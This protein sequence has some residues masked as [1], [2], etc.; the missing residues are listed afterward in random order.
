MMRSTTTLSAAVFA[1]MLA[2]SAALASSQTPQT[3]DIDDVPAGTY[4]LDSLH[5]KVTWAVDH[6]GFSTYQ[7]QFSGITG[8]L[9]LADDPADSSLN[10]EIP[11][12]QVITGSAL[13]DHLQGEDFF[14]TSQHATAT[15]TSTRIEMD[16]DDEATIHGDL[17]LN[18]QTHPLT[19]DAHFNRAAIYPFD[20]T[21]RLGFDGEATLTR[22]EWGITY[23]LPEGD[24]GM[25]ISDDVELDI[26]AEFTPQQ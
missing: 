24:N 12:D 9:E 4:S 6:Y 16:G 18:G 10:I 23:I 1:G 21:Y 26:E 3:Q 22:S 25:G 7:G 17:T 8:T 11:L 15:F 19:I 5:S 13:D 20:E 14:N 2:S